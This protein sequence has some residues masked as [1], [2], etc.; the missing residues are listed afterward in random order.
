MQLKNLSLGLF[1]FSL[2]IFS[3]QAKATGNTTTPLIA[4]QNVVAD[5]VL[6]H[7][8]LFKFKPNTAASD[9]QKVEAAFTAYRGRFHKYKDLNGART[10]A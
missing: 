7:V 1:I 6:R 8:V 9:I 10:I 3:L 2:G 5:S 4:E